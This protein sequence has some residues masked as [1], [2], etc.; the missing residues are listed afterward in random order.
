MTTPSPALPS[1]GP[2]TA[3]VVPC[4]NEARRLDPAAFERFLR[5][6]AAVELLF[7]DDGSSDRTPELLEQLRKACRGRARVLALEQNSGK[8]EAVRQ[9]MLQLLDG[10]ARYVGFWDADLAT[11][12]DEVPR[13]ARFL[14]AHP[15]AEIV[16]GSR[17]K[18]LGRTVERKAWRHYSGRVFATLVSLMLRLPVYD[19]QCGAKLFRATPD[20]KALLETPFLTRWVFDVEIIARLIAARGGEGPRSAQC[21]IH[22]VP[23]TQWVHVG[24]SKLRASDFLK[25]IYDLARI[26]TTYLR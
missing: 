2:T 25:T 7:V 11:P 15:D 22:E 12:L 17:V 24:G 19:T 9:G 3:I 10:S 14:D 26:Y 6:E 5:A 1:P 20:L 21:V 13:F 18:L 23:L 8:A 4:Y 16:F